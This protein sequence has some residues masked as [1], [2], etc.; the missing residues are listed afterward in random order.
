MRHFRDF[1]LCLTVPVT[2]G[3][4][5]FGQQI[6]V[7]D[8]SGNLVNQIISLFIFTSSFFLTKLNR[9]PL[10]TIWFSLA[11]MIGVLLLALVSVFWSEYPWLTVRRSSHLLIEVIS[12][13]LIALA[14]RDEPESLLTR[15]FYIF[16]VITL[17]NAASLAVPSISFSPI[18]FMGI[19]YHKNEAGAFFFC[20]I[21]L[22]A[23]GILN[24][25]TSKIRLAAVLLFLIAAG[26]FLLTQ[27]KSAWVCVLIGIPLTFGLRLMIKGHRHFRVVMP[28]MFLAFGFA[29]LLIIAD[30]G[31]DTILNGIF[32]DTT[33]TG[34]SDIWQFALVK[35]YSEPVHGI[36]YGALWQT[37]VEIE[38]YL[39]AYDVIGA[40]NEAHNGYIDILAQLG[41]LGVV[42]LIVFLAIVS[43]RLCRVI[44]RYENRHLAGIGSYALYLL[45]GSLIYNISESSFFHTGISLW[46]MLVLVSTCATGRLAKPPRLIQKRRIFT[47]QIKT[48]AAQ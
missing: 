35:F 33:L 37:G 22:F 48:V 9:I 3:I 38:Q 41:A 28:L 39:S 21:P 45:I 13:I 24:R 42:L 44:N 29:M 31:V 25:N 47:T 34:R 27:S 14:Y 32:G 10:R 16:G 6:S 4:P 43:I 23:L 7:T 1:L 11:P 12:L 5:I 8:P 17:A 26:L 18:G 15:L 46:V 20:A 2:F 30:V 40:V 36:G 19:H